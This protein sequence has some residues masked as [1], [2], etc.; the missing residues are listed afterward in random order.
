M[1]IDLKST[2]MSGTIP[3]DALGRISNLGKFLIEYEECLQSW[4]TN[5]FKHLNYRVSRPV[6]NSRGGDYTNHDRKIR[7]AR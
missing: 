3:E 1:T 2:Y 5:I 4:D 6:E 7:D